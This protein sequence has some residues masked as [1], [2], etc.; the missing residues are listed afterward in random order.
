V[1]PPPVSE[2]QWAAIDKRSGCGVIVRARLWFDARNLATTALTVTQ[3]RVT[4]S[5]HVLLGAVVEGETG[6]DAVQRLRDKVADAKRQAEGQGASFQTVT[7][8]RVSLTGAG[9]G[10]ESVGS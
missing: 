8:R 3:H 2:I 1:T 7:M 9:R 10:R 5:E 4:A 6:V